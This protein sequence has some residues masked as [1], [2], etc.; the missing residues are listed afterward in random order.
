M[1]NRIYKRP[2]INEMYIS[3]HFQAE[4]SIG[5]LDLQQFALKLET[6]F[7]NKKYI[8]PVIERLVNIDKIT[9]EPEKVWLHS[10]DETKLLQ[11]GR[12]RIVYNWR[13]D[14]TLPVIYPK[15]E[16]LKP[17]FLKYWDILSDY[18]KKY[19]NRKLNVK[20][21]EL[22]YSNILPIGK[23]HFLKNDKDL[24]KVL[25]FISPYPEDYKTIT[26]HINLQIPVDQGILSLRLEKIKDNKKNSE[27]FLLLFSMRINKKLDDID[28]GWY[29]KANQNI[30]Q[31]FEQMTTEN[32]KNFW[33]GEL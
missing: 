8:F 11:F 5:V 12:D 15:Y 33:T 1:E 23:D 22:Y 17:E 27:A 19:K 16:N 10:E 4:P 7:K 9:T 25:N 14:K 24:Y 32:I 3:A 20:I 31:F 18:I 29:D 30:R 21:C 28:R 6:D 2:P 26:P 13:A